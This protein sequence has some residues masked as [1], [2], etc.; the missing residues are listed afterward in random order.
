MHLLPL[1]AFVACYRVNDTFILHNRDHRLTAA[2]ANIIRVFAS[3]CHS[4]RQAVLLGRTAVGHSH[5]DVSN[6]GPYLSDCTD[7]AV[8]FHIKRPELKQDM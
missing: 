8:L 1:W 5:H 4:F 6:S 2:Y 7:C 3:R